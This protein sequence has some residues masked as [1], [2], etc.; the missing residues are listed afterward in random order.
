MARPRPTP[1]RPSRLGLKKITARDVAR[2]AGVSQPTVSRVFSRPASV[3][4]EKAERV[5]AVADALGYI[6]NRVARTLNSGQSFRIGVVLAHLRNDFFAEMLRQLSETLN[7]H[8]YSVTVYF[9]YNSPDEVD[10]IVDGLLAD[11]VDGLVLA[12]VSLSNTLVS[13]V[14]KSGIPCVLLNRGQPNASAAMVTAANVAGGRLAARFLIQGGHTRIAHLAGWGEAL[15]G[16]ERREGFMAAMAQ[17]NQTPFAVV[18]CG[19]RRTL[20]MEAARTLF[21]G[22][23]VPDAVFVAND[24]MAIGVLEVLRVELGL[25]V[26]GDVSVVGF[27]DA[28]MAAWASF[29][30]TTVR[31]PLGRMIEATV[32]LLMDRIG[33]GAPRPERIEIES[34]LIVRGSARVPQ[35]WAG[36]A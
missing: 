8:G 35:G 3:S 20:A 1:T 36:R 9:A 33:G 21:S 16:V 12:S 18:D 29:D 19:F 13:R 23:H 6:P 31:Q 15:N 28:P 10:G 24:H 5:H 27:D 22:P 26:P 32:R 4:R 14:E 11:Q 34:E 25:S 2:A 17:A 7:V 30:L